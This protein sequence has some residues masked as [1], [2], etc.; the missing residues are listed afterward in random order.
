ML[1]EQQVDDLQ[2]ESQHMYKETYHDNAHPDYNYMH[3]ST[4]EYDNPSGTYFTTYPSN[5]SEY[6]VDEQGY[7]E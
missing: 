4:V 6:N 2:C 7:K 1:N 3:E 5:A